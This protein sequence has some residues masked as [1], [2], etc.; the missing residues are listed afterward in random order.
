[1]IKVLFLFSYLMIL[2][3]CSNKRENYVKERKS[4]RAEIILKFEQRYEAVNMDSIPDDRYSITCEDFLIKKGKPVILNSTLIVDIF[5]KD[6]MNSIMR[7]KYGF[8]PAYYLDLKFPNDLLHG[9]LKNTK[10]I[11]ILVAKIESI[12]KANLLI[13]END[14]QDSNLGLGE[15]S[16]SVDIT[17]DYIGTGT[18]IN[19]E[20][21]Q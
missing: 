2:S 10:K 4:K 14:E 20:E 21:I 15:K 1:M 19:F 17:G 18:L 13:E 9:I 11:D 6:S 12:K 16:L 7:I 8:F 5:R 3:S